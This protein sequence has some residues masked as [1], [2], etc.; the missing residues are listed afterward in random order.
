MQTMELGDY[1]KTHELSLVIRPVSAD[2]AHFL[3]GD[4]DVVVLTDRDLDFSFDEVERCKL[5]DLIE[6]P[7]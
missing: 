2:A 7:E 6:G 4:E 1:E 5:G 3:Q